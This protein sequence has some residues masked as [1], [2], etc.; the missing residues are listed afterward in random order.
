MFTHP[1]IKCKTKYE[2]ED[3]DPYYCVTCKAEKDAIAAEIDARMPRAKNTAV[4]SIAQY[5]ALPKIHGFPR[6][7]P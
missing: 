4:S 2:S 5:D 7:L 6:S 1:C 3:E